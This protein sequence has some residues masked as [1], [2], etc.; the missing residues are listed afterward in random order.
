[1]REWLI[2]KRKH[3]GLTQSDLARMAGITQPSYNAIELGKSFPKL[4]TAKR[5]ASALDFRWTRFF[6][7]EEETP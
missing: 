7:E 6:E 1:M 5:I 3:A 2:Q 4:E